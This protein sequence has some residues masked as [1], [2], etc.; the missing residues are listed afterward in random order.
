MMSDKTIIQNGTKWREMIN[1]LVKD[2]EGDPSYGVSSYGY[3]C[4]LGENY[5]TN[6]E[7]QEKLT[8]KDYIPI[9]PN[10]FILVETFETFDIPPVVVG[11]SFNK[12]TYARQGITASATVIEPGWCGKL[13]VGLVNH[14]NKKVD[15]KVGAGII[16]VVFFDNTQDPCDV[17]YNGKYQGD[18]GVQVAK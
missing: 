10:Q 2:K 8:S 3:D 16:Q 6:L 5:V 17:I 7:T 11:L 13:T 4:R 1:P 15:L 18:E 14:S 9:G 12:S